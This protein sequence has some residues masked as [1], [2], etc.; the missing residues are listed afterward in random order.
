MLR[1]YITAERVKDRVTSTT[2][3]NIAAQILLCDRLLQDLVTR[4]IYEV[5]VEVEVELQGTMTEFIY[6]VELH[7]HTSI[8]NTN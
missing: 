6:T 4:C 8:N 2:T 5:E 1:D 7:K 3:E